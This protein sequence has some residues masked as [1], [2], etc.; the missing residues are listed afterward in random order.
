MYGRHSSLTRVYQ[1]CKH[2][3]VLTQERELWS[4]MFTR[5]RTIQALPCSRTEFATM[6]SQQAERVVFAA[7][8]VEAC[9]LTLE[10]IVHH[11]PVIKQL[12][13]STNA[14]TYSCRVL[15][16]ISDRFLLS[17]GDNVVIIWDMSML[18]SSSSTV[19]STPWAHFTLP[20][21]LGHVYDHSTLYIA[22]A[23]AHVDHQRSVVLDV[24]RLVLIPDRV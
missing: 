22:V 11:I 14:S 6:S 20:N 2:F 5:L 21:L 10:R 19:A 3:L 9:F 7:S 17:V 13:P 24:F 15:S 12:F 18:P 4:M 16:F 1:T 23:H 8:K